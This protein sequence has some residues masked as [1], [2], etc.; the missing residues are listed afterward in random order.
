MPAVPREMSLATRLLDFFAANH[1]EE[2][3]YDDVIAK[4]DCKRNAAYQAVDK[5]VRLGKLENVR[6][7]RRPCGMQK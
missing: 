5:L 4:F 2:L 3:T 1:G 7:I 6:V